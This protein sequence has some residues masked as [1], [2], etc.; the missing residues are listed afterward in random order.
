MSWG[1]LRHEDRYQKPTIEGR[2]AAVIGVRVRARHQA[3]A[4]LVA[5]AVF[6]P[7]LS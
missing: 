6:A 2:N 5:E 7:S 3:G 1:F 4:G